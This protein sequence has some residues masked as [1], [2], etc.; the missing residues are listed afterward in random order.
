MEVV[1]WVKKAR[2]SMIAVFTL[3]SWLLLSI[4]TYFIQYF[5]YCMEYLST[6][7]T[8][9]ASACCFTSL[10][11]YK[12]FK[13]NQCTFLQ[14]QFNSQHKWPGHLLLT[15]IANLPEK[16]HA[17]NKT[18]IKSTQDVKSNWK[19]HTKPKLLPRW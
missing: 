17:M 18:W 16:T 6:G 2:L 8:F 7:W 4:H 14:A 11:E 19:K 10:Q 12:P 15:L 9:K 1:Q 13:V 5:H 3:Y